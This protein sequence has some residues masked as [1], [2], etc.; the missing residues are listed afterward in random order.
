M[1]RFFSY[2]LD[3]Q[4]KKI[5]YFSLMS[6]LLFFLEVNAQT[7]LVRNHSFENYSQCPSNQG[8][9]NRVYRWGSPNTATP[10]YFN[11][12]VR[13]SI[14]LSFFYAHVPIN[15]FGSQ[16]PRTG[17]GYVGIISYYSNSEWREYI[18]T[19]LRCPLLRNTTYYVEFFVTLASGSKYATDDL[20]VY[21]SK[22]P[23]QY[24]NT[25]HISYTPQI[26]NPEGNVINNTSQWTIIS[27]SFVATGEEKY[28]IIGN[29]KSDANTTVSNLSAGVREYAYYYIDDVTV[30]PTGDL[31]Y[32]VSDISICSNKQSQITAF[33]GTSYLWTPSTGLSDTRVANPMITLKNTGTTP[34][35]KT[36]Y[37]TI[38]LPNGCK[39]IEDALVL[40]YPAPKIAIV[41]TDNI[42]DGKSITYANDFNES[43]TIYTWSFSEGSVSTFINWGNSCDVEWNSFN[44]GKVY[45]TATNQY[46]CSTKDSFVVKPCPLPKLQTIRWPI[47]KRE[48][49][50]QA[51][52]DIQGIARDGHTIYFTEMG[53]QTIGKL[54]TSATCS[55]A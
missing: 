15:Y 38:T 24:N 36:Y 46:G 20:G 48:T 53:K 34:V 26:T 40:V 23:I 37:V 41:T 21:F 13:V 35:T 18:Q 30:R 52:P 50:T 49:P 55:K 17:N 25:V 2:Y 33:G 43:G 19:E 5:L 39:I 44:G 31:P 16:Y 51:A 22:T 12:C 7:N 8:Q 4:W 6:K 42:C 1:N 29:F 45:L 47:P 10:D 9:I 32:G 11:T 28:M 27:G 54:K 14:D 3:F